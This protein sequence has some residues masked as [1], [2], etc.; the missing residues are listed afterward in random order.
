MLTVAAIWSEWVKPVIKTDNCQVSHVGYVVFGTITLKMDDGTRKT[1][2]QGASYTPS[3]DAHVEG[4]ERFVCI[5]VMSAEQN[6]RPAWSNSRKRCSVR[7]CV[8][9]RR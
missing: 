6:A 1:F 5:D 2:T 9:T 8:K 7:N 4:N 3:H